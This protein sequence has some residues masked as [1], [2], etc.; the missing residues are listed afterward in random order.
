MKA[1]A[2]QCTHL[3]ALSALEHRMSRRQHVMLLH[4]QATSMAFGRSF[5]VN[6]NV[7]ALCNKTLEDMSHVGGNAPAEQTIQLPC[8]HL[9]HALCIRGWTMVGK[10]NTCPTCLEKT[11]LHAL[12]A[13]R[14]WEARNLQ[15]NGASEPVFTW[16][17]GMPRCNGCILSSGRNHGQ[18][19]KCSCC[20]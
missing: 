10:K 12:Y 5:S 11:D 8:K 17:R 20:A 14:P 18:A 6:P 19:C 16:C 2:W 1:E 15:Y 9:Y 13:D 3:P 4:L 7:C